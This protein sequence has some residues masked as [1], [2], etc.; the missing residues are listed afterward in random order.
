MPII[1]TAPTLLD[2]VGIKQRALEEL[3]VVPIGQSADT[4][5]DDRIEQAYQEVYFD[6]KKRSLATWSFTGSVPNDLAP[7][8]IAL[9]AWNGITSFS[10]SDARYARIQ[11]AASQAK[12][13]IRAL[14]NHY[15]SLEEPTDF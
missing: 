5:Y 14:T 8:V 7:H 6:L 15:E 9:T 12:R 2:K 11:L 3:G 13:E 10:V 4:E 1:D